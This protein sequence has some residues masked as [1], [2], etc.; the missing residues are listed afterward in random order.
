MS[1]VAEANAT[2]TAHHTTGAKASLG[3]VMAITTRAVMMTACDTSSQLRLRPS[4]RVST[5]IGMRSTK[6]DHTHLNP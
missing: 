4:S 1:C 2:T 3:S 5:G 6:G